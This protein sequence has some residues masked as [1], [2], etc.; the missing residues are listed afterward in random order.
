[1]NYFST[2]ICLLLLTFN[3]YAQDFVTL[4]ETNI[5]TTTE[6]NLVTVTLPF[7]IVDGYH[8]QSEVDTLG[9]SIMTEIIFAENDMFELISYEFSKKHNEEVVL[10]EY[11]HFVLIDIFEVTVTLKLNDNNLKPELS[12]QLN[13]QACTNKQCLFPRT[14]NFQVLDI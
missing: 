2:T 5:E 8:I 13:Y 4:N 11:T 9:D 3:S 1:M 10:N 12:G 14:L 7:K 6:G